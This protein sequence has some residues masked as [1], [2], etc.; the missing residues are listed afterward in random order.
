MFHTVQN[1]GQCVRRVLSWV[2]GWVN[3]GTSKP[4]QTILRNKQFNV[5]TLSTSNMRA[6]VLLLRC[7][8]KLPFKRVKG[9]QFGVE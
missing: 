4:T 9:Q 5:R 3:R 6:P 2:A 7:N 1:G 8:H